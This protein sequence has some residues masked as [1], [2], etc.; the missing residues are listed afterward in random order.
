M[1]GDFFRFIFLT[2][3]FLIS[4]TPSLKLFEY[5]FFINDNS[6]AYFNIY[7]PFIWC[8]YACKQKEQVIESKINIYLHRFSA[9]KSNKKLVTSQMLASF[10]ASFCSR[11]MRLIRALTI[12]CL[13]LKYLKIVLLMLLSQDISKSFTQA[14]TKHSEGN[15]QFKSNFIPSGPSL[16]VNEDQ[17]VFFVWYKHGTK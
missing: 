13:S 3:V 9:T 16:V 7:A 17:A 8:I 6:D 5:L 14:S 4:T 12:T 2:S 15:F 11:K 1:F 10:R